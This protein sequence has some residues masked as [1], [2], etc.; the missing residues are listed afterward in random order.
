[1]IYWRESQWPFT[2]AQIVELSTGSCVCTFDV[3]VQELTHFI[4]YA[5][6]LPLF[7]LFHCTQSHNHFHF[8]TGLP[9]FCFFI[10]TEH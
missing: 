4:S 5:C 10:A 7:V 9:V 8:Q 2:L 3:K 1:M 6:D